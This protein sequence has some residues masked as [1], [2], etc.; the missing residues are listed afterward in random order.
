VSGLH[1]E[2]FRSFEAAAPLAAAVQ[3]LNLVSRRPS[4][5]LTFSYMQTFLAHDEF[6]EEGA[7]PLLLAA[8]RG[9]ELVGFLAL[10]RRRL[11][12]FGMPCVKV[13]TLVTHDIDRPGMV[14]R[15]EDEAACADAFWRYLTAREK[16][17]GLVEIQ[18]QEA[19]SPLAAPA[20]LGSRFW[21]RRFEHHPNATLLLEH[22]DPAAYFSSLSDNQRR[23]IRHAANRL[24]RAGEVEVVSSRDPLALP[25]LLDLYLDVERRSWKAGSSA[26]LS[27]HPVRVEFFR[28]LARP[29]QVPS[30]WFRFLLLNGLPIA[31]E[32]N[33]SFA[34]TEYGLEVVY[35]EDYKDH[36]AP[37][38]LFLVSLG[39]AIRSGV[40]AFNLMNNFAWQKSRWG[41]VITDL[42]A[43][44]VFRTASLF[45]L[46][47][48]LGWVRRRLSRPGPSQRHA[49]VNLSK[50]SVRERSPEST[51]AA[52]RQRCGDVLSDLERAGAVV[53]RLSGASL[54]EALPFLPAPARFAHV[55]KASE[56]AVRGP[57]RA[58]RGLETA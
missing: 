8:R 7:Q 34:D 47:A 33:A 42:A 29:G 44:Q 10:R 17:W 19:E 48:A 35:D 53:Q 51:A 2:V 32:L 43:V 38:I 26:A 12:V 16:G 22:G 27:R 54:L 6:A 52:A 25:A 14:S 23:S 30:L 15:P 5:F 13:E 37:N 18:E 21:T 49:R 56:P 41:A 36:G 1:V 24:Y 57:G 4:P 31:A 9:E 40:R 11:R 50:P 39:E 46:K 20:G 58:D 55:R 28:A 45:S 3:A